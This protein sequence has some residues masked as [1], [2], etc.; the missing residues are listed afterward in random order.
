MS[1]QHKRSIELTPDLSSALDNA[2]A[3]GRYV[4]IDAV[5]N[6]ALKIWTKRE[7]SKAESV[8]Y[9]RAL[10]QEGID[11]GPGRTIDFEELKAEMHAEFERRKDASRA[12]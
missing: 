3:S 6:D 7:A 9:L 2:V 5:I 11:S 8:E 4:S 12:S 10:V 1:A